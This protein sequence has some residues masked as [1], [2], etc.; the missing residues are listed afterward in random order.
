M[1]QCNGIVV[2]KDSQNY[3]K[4]C[5]LKTDKIYCAYHEWQC[6]IS[7]YCVKIIKIYLQNM[8]LLE[9]KTDKTKLCDELFTFLVCNKEFTHHNSR[10]KN[11]VYAKLNELQSDWPKAEYFR[12]ELFNE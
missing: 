7:E 4:R 3:G 9:Y 6:N 8:N 2:R 10:F 1:N 5:S 11:V 12:K